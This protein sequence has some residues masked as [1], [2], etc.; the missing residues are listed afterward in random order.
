MRGLMIGMCLLLGGCVSLSRETL[1]EESTYQV[2]H[3]V[4]WKQTL[5]GA[6]A[7]PRYFEQYGGLGWAVGRTPTD[8]QINVAMGVTAGVHYSVTLLLEAWNAP[9]WVRRSWQAVT[10]GSAAYTVGHNWSIGLH[11]DSAS[12]QSNWEK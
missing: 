10:I 8:T 4:D 12:P 9:R 6:N 2:I 3:A 1:V 11:I 5:E 7:H